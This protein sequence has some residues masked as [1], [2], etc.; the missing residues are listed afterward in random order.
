MSKSARVRYKTEKVEG[1]RRMQ[2]DLLY[3]YQNNVKRYPV[4]QKYLREN[5]PPMLVIWGKNDAFFLEKGAAAYKHDLKN[6]DYNILDTG[7]FVL[8]EE[9]EFAIGK[10]RNFFQ[11]VLYNLSNKN[12]KN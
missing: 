1:Q 3:D 10:M 9:S 11:N 8:E 12:T 4:W 2:L 5:Q 6:I 7:H